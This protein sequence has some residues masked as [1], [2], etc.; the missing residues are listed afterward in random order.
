MNAPAVSSPRVGPAI[1][2]IRVRDLVKRYADV[3]AVNGLDLEIRSGECFG[4]LGPNGAG[5][6]TTIEI[7]E[8]L[9]RPDAGEVQVLGQ[10][11][12]RGADRALRERLGIQLQETKLQE[13]LSV[14]ETLELFRSFYAQGPSPDEVIRRVAL[15]EK[16]D[17]WVVKLSGGQRQR[18]SLAC[19]LVN[20]PEL[21]FLDEPTT[22]LDPQSRRQLWDLIESFRERGGTTVLTT[23]YMDEAERLCDRVAIMDHGR[24]IALGTPAELIASLGAEHVVEFSVEGALDFGAI[25]RLAS[26]RQARREAA[27]FSL[28]VGEPHVA[29]PALLAELARQQVQLQRLTTHHATLE[30]VFMSMTGRTLRDE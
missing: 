21:L 24:V 14:L 25:E 28:I 12:T 26:V 16:R 1:P 13:K 8:G 2:A 18:L 3:V 30:D 11:W 10:H 29:I 5:K 9:T 27:G 4:L 20:D 17:A 15:E 22:G 6:T 7:L 23:H 19:A